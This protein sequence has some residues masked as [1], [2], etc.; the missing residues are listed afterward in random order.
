MLGLPKEYV[1]ETV[2]TLF[3]DLSDNAF[4]KPEHSAE[5]LRRRAFL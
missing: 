3:Q 2:K 4:I 5:W 1:E